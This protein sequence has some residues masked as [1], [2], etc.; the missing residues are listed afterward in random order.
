M[1][2]LHYLTKKDLKNS[3]GQPLRFS[4][5]SMFGAEYNENA[6]VTGTNH[7]KRSWYANVTMKDGKIFA[8]K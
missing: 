3:V 2:V 4:E 7:P 5:T 1:L 8:V 6:V